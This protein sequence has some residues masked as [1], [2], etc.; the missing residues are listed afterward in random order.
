MN[1]CIHE[2]V[3]SLFAIAVLCDAGLL[4]ML[5]TKNGVNYLVPS[6]ISPIVEYGRQHTQLRTVNFLFFILTTYH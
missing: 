4:A 5:I 2:C 3:G 6:N 1:T